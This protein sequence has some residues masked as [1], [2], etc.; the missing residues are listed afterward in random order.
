M[1]NP[2]IYVIKTPSDPFSTPDI[3]VDARG[4]ELSGYRGHLGSHR[5]GAVGR[6]G[7]SVYSA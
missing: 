5:R 3:A 4:R 1:F 6:A 7:E 2:H